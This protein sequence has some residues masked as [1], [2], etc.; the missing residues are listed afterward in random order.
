MHPGDF[1]IGISADGGISLHGQ[2]KGRVAKVP[3][4]AASSATYSPNDLASSHSYLYNYSKDDDIPCSE[5]RG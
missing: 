1:C 5:L 3:G 2:S 4:S